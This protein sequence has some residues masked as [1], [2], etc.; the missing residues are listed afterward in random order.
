M[1]EINREKADE[2]IAGITCVMKGFYLEQRRSFPTFHGVDST[3]KNHVI[4]LP[5]EAMDHDVLKEALC[6]SL[7]L[8]SYIH[9]IQMYAFGDEVWFT[10]KTPEDR[11][12][13]EYCPPSKDATRREA[14]FIVGVLKDGST[15]SVAYE[16][17]RDKNKQFYDLLKCD[18]LCTKWDDGQYKYRGRFTELLPPAEMPRTPEL[19]EKAKA[20]LAKM[21]FNMRSEEIVK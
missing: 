14:L 13:Q 16:I 8:Y 20:E 3:G 1:V 11:A 12:S 17:L 21:P 7:F 6:A 18:D 15:C 19:I 2:V 9:D 5:S 10:I 4:I